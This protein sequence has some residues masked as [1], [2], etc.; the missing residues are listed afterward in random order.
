MTEMETTP[1]LTKRNHKLLNISK[2]CEIMA[3]VVLVLYLI[4][5]YTSFT[6]ITQYVTTTDINTHVKSY[7]NVGIGLDNSFFTQIVD[8]PLVLIKVATKV[9]I[10]IVRG[11]LGF[12][13][14]YGISYG[15][16]MLVETDINYR[17]KKGEN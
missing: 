10:E 8:N 9:S 11:V 16:K 7:D 4:N 14:L 5:S 1:V 2:F 12:L 6:T 15:L 17:L 3:W 13:T